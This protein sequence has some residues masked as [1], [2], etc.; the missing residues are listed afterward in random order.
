MLDRLPFI[1]ELDSDARS[2]L[3]NASVI[4][5]P[6]GRT[7]LRPGEQCGGFLVLLEGCVRVF[8][9]SLQGRELDM[10][11]IE[12]LGTCVLTTSCLLSGQVYPAEACVEA[13]GQAVVISADDF[14]AL[15]DRSSAFRN[16]VF[17]SYSERLSGLLMLIQSVAFERMDVRLARYLLK[18]SGRS[19]VLSVSHQQIADAL[20][21]AREVVSRQ[22]KLMEQQGWVA[23]SRGQ[24]LM[25]EP[26][27]LRRLVKNEGTV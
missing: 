6:V 8:G 22:L 25:L 2:L 4:N 10:Y 27:I 16:Y 13:A 11:R 12:P 1:N 26:D 15:M 23:L 3:E 20:G 21:T 18:E 19:L 17:T 24:V 14:S 7:L 5:L 9:R